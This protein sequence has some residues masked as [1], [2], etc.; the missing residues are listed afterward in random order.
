MKSTD[1]AVRGEAELAWAMPSAADIAKNG[2]D[3]TAASPSNTISTKAQG[4]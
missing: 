4:E 2:E 1:G 3:G